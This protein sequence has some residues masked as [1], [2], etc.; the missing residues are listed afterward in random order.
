VRGYVYEVNWYLD[1]YRRLRIRVLVFSSGVCARE[2]F[3]SQYDPY[4]WENSNTIVQPPLAAKIKKRTLNVGFGD[5][6]QTSRAVL[7]EGGLII[8]TDQ[9]QHTEDDDPPPEEALF[10]N[11][12]LLILTVARN[13]DNQL[14]PY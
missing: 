6:F 8:E 14:F 1:D 12:S 7:I 11:P 2:Y 13:L 10:N 3:Q 5:K 4:F 9:W